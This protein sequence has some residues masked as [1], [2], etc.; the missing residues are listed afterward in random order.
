MKTGNY[1]G[2]MLAGQW[3]RAVRKFEVAGRKRRLAD[4]R[5]FDRLIEALTRFKPKDVG[6]FRRAVLAL[7]KKMQP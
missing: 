4:D 6:A 5:D 1:A 2:H 7:R 3:R